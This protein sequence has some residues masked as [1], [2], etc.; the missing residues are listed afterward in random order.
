MS[1]Y[2]A[3]EI[4]DEVLVKQEEEYYGEMTLYFAKGRVVAFKDTKMNKKADK[5][6]IRKR[7]VSDG[8]L[9]RR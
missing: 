1:N 6:T 9:D 7:G 5:E 8:L 2:T 3:D 4:R